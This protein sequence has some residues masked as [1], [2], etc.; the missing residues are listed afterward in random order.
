MS[1]FLRATLK[2]IQGFIIH[3]D[4][5]CHTHAA[6]DCKESE[7]L[8]FINKTVARVNEKKLPLLYM[9]IL[10]YYMAIYSGGHIDH[11]KRTEKCNKSN[12]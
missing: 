10:V 12:S 5:K 3:T 4:L 6:T 11:R 8:G 9:P 2:K 7:V 1:I